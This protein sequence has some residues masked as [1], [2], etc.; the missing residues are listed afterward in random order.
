M[1]NSVNSVGI[2][3]T[4]PQPTPAS[5]NAP[6]ATANAQAST[7]ANFQNQVPVTV[8]SAAPHDSDTP[9]SPRIVVDPLAGPITEFLTTSGQVQAQIPSAAVVAY[10]RAGLTAEGFAKPTPETTHTDDK[11]KGDAS[12][13]D[14][15][16]VV[17]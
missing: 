5:G 16:S 1:S 17:A 2:Q 12:K 7:Q 3:N 14:S 8:Q 11:N 10:L 6:G 9:I 13:P 4:P 15:N